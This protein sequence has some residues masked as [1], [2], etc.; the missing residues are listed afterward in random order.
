MRM[1]GTFFLFSAS[2]LSPPTAGLPRKTLTR[3]H[4]VRSVCSLRS[5]FVLCPIKPPPPRRAFARALF[6]PALRPQKSQD[7]LRLGVGPVGVSGYILALMILAIYVPGA[8]YMY[9]NMVGNRR[10]AFKKRN[11]A[12]AEAAKKAA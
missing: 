5:Y 1:T 10:S 12:A 4:R 6:P 8:P 11:A 9:M 7:T 3:S 2:R